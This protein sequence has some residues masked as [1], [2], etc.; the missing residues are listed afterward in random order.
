MLKR[1]LL[2]TEKNVWMF[3][4]KL[5]NSQS[6]CEFKLLVGLEK[7]RNLGSAFG[8]MGE[9]IELRFQSAQRIRSLREKKEAE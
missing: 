2:E 8:L 1:N 4:R 9:Q 3:H 7:A 6:M 5:V